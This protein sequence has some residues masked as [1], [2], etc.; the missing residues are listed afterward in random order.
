M[1][2][3]ITSISIN[4]NTMS[5]VKKKT[6]S[7]IVGFTEATSWYTYDFIAP[8]DGIILVAARLTTI[9]SEVWIFNNSISGLAEM[10]STTRANQDCL[11]TCICNE[12]DSITVTA[13]NVDANANNRIQ[14]IY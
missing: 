13:S 12:G 14:I 11:A 6:T 1:A 5:I 9:G 2:K 7:K 3:N 8:H 10:S 4:G